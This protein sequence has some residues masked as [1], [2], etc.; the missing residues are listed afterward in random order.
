MGC[1]VVQPLASRGKSVWKLY[2]LTHLAQVRAVTQ[3]RAYLSSRAQSH[4]TLYLDATAVRLA[5]GILLLMRP[6]TACFNPISSIFQRVMANSGNANHHHLK[7]LCCLMVGLGET[8]R[9]LR[10]TEWWVTSLKQFRSKLWRSGDGSSLVNLY[11]F[12]S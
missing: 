5:Q 7:L 1:K 9:I 10:G 3:L 11:V 2:L 6:S 8:L 4:G 12:P